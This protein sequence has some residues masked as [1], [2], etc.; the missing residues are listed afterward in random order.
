M[1]QR[2]PFANFSIDGKVVTVI[3]VAESGVATPEMAQRSMTA[4]KQR[5]KKDDIVLVAQGVSLSPTFIG[6]PGYVDKL[7]NMQL[8]G[9]QWGQVEM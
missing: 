3:M 9:V 5:L 7:K 8:G 6:A 4:F 1:G 2:F